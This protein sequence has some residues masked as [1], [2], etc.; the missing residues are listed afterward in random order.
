[1]LLSAIFLNESR[2]MTKLYAGCYGVT[3]AGTLVLLVASKFR[4]IAIEAA[5]PVNTTLRAIFKYFFIRSLEKET[6]MSPL[7]F[8]GLDY[9][10]QSCFLM[11]CVILHMSNIP[12]YLGQLIFF[13]AAPLNKSPEQYRKLDTCGDTPT[14]SLW[15]GIALLLI[16]MPFLLSFHL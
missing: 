9:A 15:W 1:M 3:F 4:L 5:I 8:A 16:C 2:V 12:F 10:T 14:S 6:C 11:E 7:L 13:V